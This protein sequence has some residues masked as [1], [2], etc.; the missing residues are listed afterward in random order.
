MSEAT[1]R[2]RK[3]AAGASPESLTAGH[4]EMKR[5]L[6]T[7]VSAPVVT[8]EGGTSADAPTIPN[9]SPWNFGPAGV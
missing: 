5:R 2:G 6:K 7:A 1:V 3:E 8:S 4:S 9:K